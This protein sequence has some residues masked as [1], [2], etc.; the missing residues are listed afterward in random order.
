LSDWNIPKH[1]AN[2]DWTENADGSTTVKVFPYDTTGDPSESTPASKPWFQTTFSPL[3]GA[4]PFSTDTYA[5]LGINATLAQPPLPNGNGD[6][7]LGELPGTETWAATVP[8]EASDQTWL[9]VF[10][11]QQPNGGDAFAENGTN[12]V[13]DEYFEH[14]WPG[15]GRFNI[16]LRQDNA[17]ITFDA[18]ER[19]S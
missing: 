1:L 2:F 6:A 19:W 16:G 4:V 9:G 10:D 5:Y 17:T 7:S 14:F 11:L 18:P 8:G 15:M 3:A 13:G 12:A